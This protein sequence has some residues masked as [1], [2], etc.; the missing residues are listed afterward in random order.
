MKA[1]ASVNS[2][3][4]A[5]RSKALSI[6]R[7]LPPEAQCR[8]LC[9]TRHDYCFAEELMRVAVD[10]QRPRRRLAM[11]TTRARCSSAP[12]GLEDRAVGGDLNRRWTVGRTQRLGD[13]ASGTP[14]AALQ[15]LRHA[16]GA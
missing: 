15:H 14:G 4:R 8:R 11:P 7:R 2:M 1:S 13:L 5:M 16:E 9:A 10:R 6:T 12:I 3:M